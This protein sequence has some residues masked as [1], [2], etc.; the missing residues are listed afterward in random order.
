MWDVQCPEDFDRYLN[1]QLKRL[2]T[3]HVDYYLF[4][5]LTGL[6]WEEIVLK[7]NLIE[8]AEAAVK[9][10]RIGHLGFSF[11]DSYDAFT[12]IID[13]YNGWALCQIQYNYM[14]TDVQAGIR[15]LR[16]AANKELAV[17][18][19]EPLL[20]GRLARPPKA[21]LPLFDEHPSPRSP[22]EWAL[23][24][25]WD[26]PE[27]SLVLSGMNSM[28]QVRENLISADSS[29]VGLMT[30]EDRRF[31]ERVKEKFLERAVV[32]CTK[33]GYCLPCPSGVNIPA[34]FE[35]YNDG[36]MYDNLGPA[37][38]YYHRLL[39]EQQRASACTGCRKCESQC[40]QGIKIADIMPKIHAALTK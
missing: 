16:Y 3:D 37:R 7:F 12:R 5:A 11:H 18:I 34:C 31:L 15:G 22:S 32:P 20:G 4:H 13:G 35:Y 39:P 26:Q 27:V 33:C 8:K 21:V 29:G 28:A 14:G 6:R 19:M 10:G 25:L 17:V 40:P 24:W 1:E 38:F 36:V 2:G 23:R 9:D 30:G